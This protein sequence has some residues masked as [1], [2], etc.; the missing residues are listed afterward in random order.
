MDAHEVTF[1]PLQALSL[2]R[3]ALSDPAGLPDGALRPYE[4]DPAADAHGLY[5]IDQIDAAL[6]ALSFEAG[7]GNDDRAQ[8]VWV[9]THLGRLLVEVAGQLDADWGEVGGVPVHMNEHARSLHRAV[10]LV[11]GVIADLAG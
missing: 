11:D 4:V 7:A 2:A 9:L 6:G 8:A 1:D 5:A 3:T 10:D